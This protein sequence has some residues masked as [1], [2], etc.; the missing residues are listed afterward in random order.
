MTQEIIPWG[1]H[2]LIDCLSTFTTN[3][4]ARHVQRRTFANRTFMKEADLA[5]RL[6]AQYLFPKLP[7]EDLSKTTASAAQAMT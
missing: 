2:Y 3:A 5:A 1:Q 7:N 4:S 6:F